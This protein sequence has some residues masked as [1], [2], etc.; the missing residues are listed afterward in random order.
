M[1]LK[2]KLS[3][4]VCKVIKSVMASVK[5]Y[6]NRSLVSRLDNSFG[7]T[8]NDVKFGIIGQL[9]CPEYI[10]IGDGTGFGDWLYLTAWDTFHCV[11]NGKEEIQHFIPSLTIGE[12]CHFGAFNHITCINRVEIGNRLLTGKWVTITDNSHGKTD[13]DTLQVAPIERPLYSKGPVVIGNDVWMGDKVTILANVIIGDGAVIA[14]NSV[15]TEDVPAYSVVAGNPAKIIKHN[16][17]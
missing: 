2:R 9:R 14:A 7:R 12:N 15:V 11:V 3:D 1:T 16:V 8:I 17:E 5:R 10:S 4:F 13:K 6:E